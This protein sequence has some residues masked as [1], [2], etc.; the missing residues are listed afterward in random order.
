MVCEQ[1]IIDTNSEIML[2]SNKTI[3]VVLI[4]WITVHLIPGDLI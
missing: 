4:V 2:N 1:A 3:S